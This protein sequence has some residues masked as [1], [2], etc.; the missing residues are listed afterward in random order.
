MTELSI[1]AMLYF[2][3]VTVVVHRWHNKLCRNSRSIG[4]RCPGTCRPFATSHS[5]RR[6][7]YSPACHTRGRSSKA[8]KSRGPHWHCWPPWFRNSSRSPHTWRCTASL[9]NQNTCRWCSTMG[10]IAGICRWYREDSNLDGNQSHSFQWGTWPVQC[11]IGMSS[12]VV[13]RR[14]ENDSESQS[15]TRRC[16]RMCTCHD[17]GTCSSSLGRWND[18]SR[19]WIRRQY[20]YS[21]SR[22]AENTRVCRRRLLWSY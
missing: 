21:L 18:G 12:L 11:R 9:P 19:S 7:R 13:V 1:S 14:F 3:T 22:R 16:K 2:K 4:K 17:I 15:N 6:P 5:R 10:S 20:H 8:N